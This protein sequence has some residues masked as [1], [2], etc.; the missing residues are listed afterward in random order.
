MTNTEQKL[1]KAV[2]LLVQSLDETLNAIEELD[3]LLQEKEDC[4][5]TAARRSIDLAKLRVTRIGDILV[6]IR[7]M[8]MQDH[9]LELHGISRS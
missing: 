5:I 6:E 1:F 2:D 7:N 9:S 4:E 3:P 8:E